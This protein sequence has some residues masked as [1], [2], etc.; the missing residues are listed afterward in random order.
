MLVFHE[1]FDH[2][3]KVVRLDDIRIAGLL[4]SDDGAA[5]IKESYYV[6]GSDAAVLG[7]DMEDFSLVLDIVIET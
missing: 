3:L 1:F 2:L 6:G 7:L 4:R 5:A